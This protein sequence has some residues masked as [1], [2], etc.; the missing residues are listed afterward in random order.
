MKRGQPLGYQPGL[1]GLRAVG[2]L[3]VLFFHADFDWAR[4]G[5]LG[6]STFFTLSGFLIT[7]LLLTDHVEHGGVRFANF[8]SR[9]ARRLLPAAWAALGLAVLFGATVADAGQLARLQRCV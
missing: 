2:V 9:C 6:V 7:T 3:G 1:D 5:W 4:G 8:W